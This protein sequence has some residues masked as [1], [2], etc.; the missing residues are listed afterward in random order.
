MQEYVASGHADPANYQPNLDPIYW[1]TN[2]GFM[3][4]QYAPMYA[5]NVDLTYSSL[6]QSG[7]NINTGTSFGPTRSGANVGMVMSTALIRNGES[8]NVPLVIA[9][10]EEA[11]RTEFTAYR[12]NGDGLNLL[13]NIPG[14]NSTGN[15]RPLVEDDLKANPARWNRMLYR[16]FYPDI[17]G[18]LNP[19]PDAGLGTNVFGP[20]L[21]ATTAST[22]VL[23]SLNT[24]EVSMYMITPGGQQ[25][26]LGLYLPATEYSIGS[27]LEAIGF[28]NG[29]Y[30]AW[31]FE[32]Q[33][34]E[35]T[36]IDSVTCSDN[37]DFTFNEVITTRSVGTYQYKIIPKNL[38]RP[39]I[40]WNTQEILVTVTVT[41][42]ENLMLH[43]TIEYSHPRFEI[44]T[45]H[46]PITGSISILFIILIIISLNICIIKLTKNIKEKTT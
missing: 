14:P 34:M 20:A 2:A 40:F 6:Y 7:V 10:S 22:P 38:D 43:H 21:T 19:N 3:R 41:R 35:G 1:H 31:E 16:H 37:E 39:N 9:D 11:A 33:D 15:W 4:G 26:I 27:H 24:S 42:D 12:T 44:R 32:L 17:P 25:G 8:S 46:F 28:A 18:F 13:A 23:Y 29:M 45:R 5:R 30:D 36:V